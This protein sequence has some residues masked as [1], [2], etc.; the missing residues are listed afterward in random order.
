MLFLPS[1]PP[2]ANLPSQPLPFATPLRSPPF[3]TS[4]SQLPFTTA[5]HNWPPLRQTHPQQPPST[6]PLNNPSLK[7]LPQQPLSTSTLLIPCPFWFGRILGPCHLFLFS[8][9]SVRQRM[10][11]MCQSW[12]WTFPRGG[13]FSP[14]MSSFSWKSS[15]SALS[16]FCPSVGVRTARAQQQGV[17]TDC[18]QGQFDARLLMSPS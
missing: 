14:R 2:L 9:F 4:P 12:R 10:H 17:M 3:S 7:N 1:Q 13:R 5:L 8:A 6:A 11:V 18:G 16:V 15:S